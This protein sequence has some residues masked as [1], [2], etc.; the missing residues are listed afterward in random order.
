MK[1]TLAKI[2]WILFA[3]AGALFAYHV[4]PGKLEWVHASAVIAVGLGMFFFSREPVSDERVEHLKLQAVRASFV[5]AIVLTLLINMFVLNPAE[6]DIVSHSLSAFDF[7]AVVMLSASGLFYFW[8][9]RDGRA[10]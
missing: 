5:P 9:W 2:F 10:N 4:A 8:R 1:P 7:A 3:A 6:P